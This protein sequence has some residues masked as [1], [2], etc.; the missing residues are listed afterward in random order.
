M[1][2]SNVHTTIPLEQETVVP[3]H[4]LPD[5]TPTTLMELHVNPRSTFKSDKS[6]PRSPR[7][8][9]PA[10]ELAFNC[11]LV[12]GPLCTKQ[13]SQTHRFGALAAGGGWGIVASEAGSRCGDRKKREGE[14]CSTREHLG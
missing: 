11:E 7:S 2:S 10:A 3:S 4:E 9:W 13:Y 6:M 14:E 8:A 1:K 5:P 12:V